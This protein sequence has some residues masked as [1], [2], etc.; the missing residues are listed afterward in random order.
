MGFPASPQS[1]DKSCLG[2]MLRHCLHPV[3]LLLFPAALLA[4]VQAWM[5]AWRGGLGR[6]ADRANPAGRDSLLNGR[7]RA[8]QAVQPCTPHGWGPR[9]VPRALSGAG[10]EMG[11]GPCPCHPAAP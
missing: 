11:A 4:C 5:C 10:R 7:E 2:E 1:P 9:G 6:G 8:F 3:L